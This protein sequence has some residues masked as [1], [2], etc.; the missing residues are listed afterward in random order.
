MTSNTGSHVRNRHGGE[1]S[2]GGGVVTRD[3]HGPV[4]FSPQITGMS[5]GDARDGEQSQT[6]DIGNQVIETGHFNHQAAAPMVNNN[7][8]AP[9]TAN[10]IVDEEGIHITDG[11]LFLS[12]YG[13]ASVLGP[14]GFDGAWV[15]YLLGGVYNGGFNA[16]ITTWTTEGVTGN[17]DWISTTTIQN[18]AETAEDYLASL[19]ATIPYW[20]IS[21]HNGGAVRARIEAEAVLG[22]YL[23]VQSLAVGVA[24]DLGLMT[25]VQDVPVVQ[26]NEYE[27]TVSIDHKVDG[28]GGDNADSDIVVA[29]EWMDS[30][31]A[32]L[33]ASAGVGQITHDIYGAGGAGGV[34]TYALGTAPVLAKYARLHL[35]FA[36][37]ADSAGAG[38]SWLLYDVKLRPVW[39]VGKIRFGN[40]VQGDI[41]YSALQAVDDGIDVALADNSA[42]FQRMG[43]GI[44][45]TD[46]HP[47]VGIGAGSDG[48]RIEFGPGDAVS[49]ISL[50]RSAANVLSLGSGDRLEGFL[51]FV[52]VDRITVLNATTASSISRTLTGAISGIPADAI[53][54]AGYGGI[55]S[56]GSQNFANYFNVFQTASGINDVAAQVHVFGVGSAYTNTFGFT[57]GAVQ[58]GGAKISY[59][60]NRGTGTITYSLFVTGYFTDKVT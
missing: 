30:T 20:V 43:F 33:G 40:T 13:G 37:P 22:R 17:S 39:Q 28:S 45:D 57:C 25:F 53:M 59:Q 36:H 29:V 49:D 15:E 52:P 6:P 21:A 10:V 23:R 58:S 1:G 50:A 16:G 55:A 56:D 26:G 46:D 54:L 51:R 31:H 44:R 60:I 34:Y 11:A 5:Y 38:R 4:G 7:P 47:R 9:T 48:G 19:S 32:S 12:D 2:A 24:T 41:T 3:T 27:T 42:G 8:V 18:D 35:T 14:V